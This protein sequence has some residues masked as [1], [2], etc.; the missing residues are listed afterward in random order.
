MVTVCLLTVKIMKI[1][2]KKYI[3][4]LFR[5]ALPIIMGNL[6]MLLLG[7]GDCLIGGRF[8]TS[9]LAAISIA[10]SIH[11]TVMMFAIGLTV[12]ISPLLSNL[13]G[14]NICTK[15]YFYP[16]IR[17]AL[18][19]ALIITFVT[20]AYIPVL[21]YLG[22]E[23]ALLKNVQIFTF[24]LAFSSFGA[25]LNVALKEFLQSYEI[26]FIPN[27]IMILSVI[28]NL[29]LNYIL[30]FGKFGIPQMG[31]A[32]IALATT[33]S[34]TVAA[35]CLL[36]FCL[37]QFRFKNFSDINYYK[38]IFKIGLPISAAIMIEFLAF[39]Y[40]AVL[41]GRV[42]GQY[43]AA[44]NIIIVICSAMFMIPMG[45][46]NALAVK[47]GYSNGAKNYHEMIKYMV[48]GAAVTLSFMTFTALILFLY[49][50]GL[51]AIFTTD[52]TLITMASPVMLLVA[53]FQVSDGLQAVLGGI[54][55]GL[56]KTGIVMSANIIAYLFVSI[57]LGTYLGIVK[58]M[59]LFG[60]WAALGISSFLLSIILLVCLIFILKR[61]KTE[62]I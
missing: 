53:A 51:V 48:N 6:G 24:I 15:K 34:R 55:K 1:F 13:R 62:Y 23:S 58:K 57:M 32:G 14:A 37:S 20:L 30:V 47:V 45:I 43:A 28:L 39:N 52:R 41:L 35:L 16:T 3:S 17:F 7:T 50:S 11:A 29:V 9:A 26:V 21:R 5:L 40:I 59:Y 61:L 8:S 12:S 22:F 60:C 19:L 2:E 46:S 44:H 56:K 33:F 36:W 38:Q 18:V 27:L 25:V 49:P 4:E 31:S 10:T 54:F 42:S